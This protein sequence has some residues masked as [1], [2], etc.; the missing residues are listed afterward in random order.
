MLSSVGPITWVIL[1]A[2]LVGKTI[3]VYGLS[4]LGKLCGFPLPDGMGWKELTITG[5]IAGIGLTV[6]LFVA[7]EAYVG[8]TLGAYQ[9]QAKMGALLSIFGFLFAWIMAKLFRVKKIN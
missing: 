6:A 1:L 3:G 7:G 4:M 9:G 2:L 5:M 8:E